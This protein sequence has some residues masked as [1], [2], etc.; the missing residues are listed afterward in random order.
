MTFNSAA[1]L[2]WGRDYSV[3]D[4]REKK[5]KWGDRGVERYEVRCAT[6]RQTQT[7]IISDSG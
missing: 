3:L 1:N 7:L 4:A 2:S 5:M 6:D